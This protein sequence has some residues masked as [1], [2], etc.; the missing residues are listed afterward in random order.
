MNDTPP[1]ASLELCIGVDKI[2]QAT[3]DLKLSKLNSL[4]IKDATVT[5]YVVEISKTN[6]NLRCK[7]AKLLQC[8]EEL[9]LK[10]KKYVIDCII[11][12]T[13]I[14]PLTEIHTNQD[15][16]FFHAYS[17]ETDFPKILE[18][19]HP[20]E[21]NGADIGQIAKINE[22]N[23][24]NA[25]VIEIYLGE[26]IPLLYGFRYI[27]QGWSPKKSAGGF[28]KFN[29]DM[30]AS[31][32]ESP[33]FKV[34]SYLDFI[35]YGD[36][37]FI[38]DC[39]RFEMAMQFKERLIERKIDTIIELKASDIFV[40]GDDEILSSAIGTDK[41]F[42]RQL[43][44]VQQKGFYKNSIWI[45]KLKKEVKFAGNWLLE[46]DALGKI[47]VKNEKSY[48][49][50]LLTVLQNKRVETIVDKMVCDVD[51]ELNAQVTKK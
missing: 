14:S 34:D 8:N 38:A 43:S 41:H 48:I 21:K 12:N 45:E 40:A 3:L 25:Y 20:L 44:S 28:F 33:V 30:V 1:L 51:G 22:L 19:L 26:D 47:I 32:D 16:R 31:F 4:N 13:Q 5:I 27:S 42:L 50:E 10:F 17:S 46:L 7:E 29:H 2:D 36:D 11:N 18:T 49:R 9:L 39:N 23:E 37:L 24:Y 15:N 35:S 6:K